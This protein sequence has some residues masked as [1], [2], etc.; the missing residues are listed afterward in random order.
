MRKE[1]KEN[2]EA[3][4]QFKKAL[5]E[6]RDIRDIKEIAGD[7]YTYGLYLLQWW[8]GHLGGKR[9]QAILSFLEVVY[10]ED[11]AISEAWEEAKG[12]ILK[13]SDALFGNDRVKESLEELKEKL[14]KIKTYKTYEDGFKPE[15]WKKKLVV[16]L[17]YFISIS[18][19]KVLLALRIFQTYAYLKTGFN[20]FPDKVIHIDWGFPGFLIDF[21]ETIPYMWFEQFFRD[22]KGKSLLTGDYKYLNISWLA[23]DLL[24][25]LKEVEEKPDYTLLRNRLL[26]KEMLPQ[27]KSLQIYKDYPD[28]FTKL[29]TNTIIPDTGERFIKYQVGGTTDIE[30]HTWIIPPECKEA[31]PIWGKGVRDDLRGLIACG[32]EYQRLYPGTKLKIPIELFLLF[33]GKQPKG[34]EYALLKARLKTI[35]YHI[36]ERRNKR[37]DEWDR[38]R[39][40]VDLDIIKEGKQQYIRIPGWAEEI[41][42]FINDF[43]L[44]IETSQKNLTPDYLPYQRSLFYEPESYRTRFAEQVLLPVS[45]SKR[46]MR[47]KLSTIYTRIGITPRQIANQGIDW[48]VNILYFCLVYAKRQGI[49]WKFDYSKTIMGKNLTTTYRGILH[50]QNYPQEKALKITWDYIRKAKKL[51]N[52]QN[53]VKLRDLDLL[54]WYIILQ[55][56]ISKSKSSDEKLDPTNNC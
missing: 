56:P 17:V 35:A 19:Q 51:A 28:R 6:G 20:P 41:Q 24:K 40:T 33:R 49:S 29:I 45:N 9:E 53:R 26:I 39:H 1:L 34:K 4:R 15:D 8:S 42:K 11:K 13:H 21:I 2:L 16:G 5:K 30:Y 38:I 52:L 55:I 23:E 43:A 46:K 7:T 32:I 31:L 50:L 27:P 25:T 12:Y 14:N 18:N 37:T 10:Q 47:Y 36:I 54:N 44:A 3:I 22:E 48:A